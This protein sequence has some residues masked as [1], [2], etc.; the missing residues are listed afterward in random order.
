MNDYESSLRREIKFVANEL[1]INDIHA[2]IL[3]SKLFLRK[4]FQDRTVNNIY[5][6]TYNYDAYSDN[7]DGISRR[8]KLRYRWYGESIEPCDGSLELKKRE[9]AFGFK[10]NQKIKLL[11]INGCHRSLSMALR[12][13]VPD[14]WLPLLDYYSVPVILNR[15]RR[16]YFLSKCKKI[17]VTIDR[18]HVVFDQRLSN[19]IN[20]TKKANTVQY[21]IVEVKFHPDLTEYVSEK[22]ADIPMRISRN[23]KY[24]NSVN[25]VL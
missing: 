22:I 25:S 2:W 13:S 17:R 11:N 24:I 4:E 18:E 5:Y 6:D 16:S 7:L 8:T 19:K 10:K 12:K 14:S 3:A 21:I 15:Y 1:F 9:N 20:I 23:S